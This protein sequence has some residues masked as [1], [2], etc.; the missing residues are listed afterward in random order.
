[1]NRDSIQTG[2]DE[3]LELIIPEP[4]PEHEEE[5]A[6]PW[7]RADSLLV[8]SATDCTHSC[9]LRRWMN[10]MKWGVRLRLSMLA[11]RL[12]W[13]L[14]ATA[15]TED[16]FQR[17]CRLGRFL[18]RNVQK[19][20]EYSIEIYNNVH[21]CPTHKEIQTHDPSGAPTPTCDGAMMPHI[22]TENEEA[23]SALLQSGMKLKRIKQQRRDDIDTFR[24]IAQ[25]WERYCEQILFRSG[26][27]RW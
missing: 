25:R 21:R 5:F 1:M 27:R 20:L 3:G 6:N 11:L 22:L 14:S 10:F 12:Q 26:W 13:F 17:W 4:H 7:H 19:I 2:D 15:R 16:S 8:L 18:P 9:R 24:T 23:R